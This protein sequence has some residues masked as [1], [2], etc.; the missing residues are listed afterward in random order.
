MTFKRSVGGQVSPPQVLK[1]SMELEDRPP[2]R[3]KEKL[4]LSS[5]PSGPEVMRGDL[6][7]CRVGKSQANRDTYVYSYVYVYIYIYM[8]VCIYIYIHICMYVCVCVYIYIYIYIYMYMYMYN[9]TLV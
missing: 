4:S 8:Y 3:Q 7:G 9:G 5:L 1:L 6:E 2:L